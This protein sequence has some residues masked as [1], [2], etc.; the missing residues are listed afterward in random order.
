MKMCNCEIAIMKNITVSVDEETHR[1][2]RI[3]AA[4]L[5]TSVSALVRGFLT[6]LAGGRAEESSNL[7][8][9]KKD[10]IEQRRQLMNEVIED[11]RATGKGF[12]AFDNLSREELY[13]RTKAR[14]EGQKAVTASKQENSNK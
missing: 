7:D 10:E 3:K 4:E 12:R 5:D 13:D 1:R 14:A 8:R 9:T 6:R 11:I 2:A